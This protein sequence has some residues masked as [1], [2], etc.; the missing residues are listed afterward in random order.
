MHHRLLATALVLA[1]ALVGQTTYVVDAAGN[2]DFIDLPAAFTA[3]THGDV[4]LVRPGTYTPAATDQGLRV[5]ADPG[6][7]L[8]NGTLAVRNL[9][10]TATFSMAGFD[11]AAGASCGLR[12]ENCTGPVHLFDIEGY[13][14]EPTAGGLTLAVLDSGAVTAVDCGFGF[15][16]P[17]IDIA[18]RASHLTLVRCQATGASGLPM[19]DPFSSRGDHAL[20]IHGGQVDCAY[21]GFGGGNGS[22]PRGTG[23][24]GIYVLGE[25][26]LRIGPGCAG[27]GGLGGFPFFGGSAGVALLYGFGGSG[28]TRCD[29]ASPS[30]GS[31]AT[32]LAVVPTVTAP[33]TGPGRNLAPDWHGGLGQPSLLVVSLAAPTQPSPWGAF[34]LDFFTSGV[35]YAGPAVAQP[36]AFPLFGTL[37]LGTTIT[38][39][40]IVDLGNEIV[41]TNAMTMVLR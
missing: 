22:G 18:G 16:I 35:I 26:E 14:T 25:M 37:P 13:V 32:Q 9:P 34:H 33:P 28:P 1:P 15:G 10:A 38:L 17:A 12:V 24:H 39:Q 41:L 27:Q 29:P 31:R 8:G 4:L 2:G 3:A 21:S 11:A 30:L 6:A 19:F 23:G 5:L 20:V 7:R 40:G 36:P